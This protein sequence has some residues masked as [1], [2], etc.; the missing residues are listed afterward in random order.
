MEHQT[1][2]PIHP[3]A[4]PVILTT[5]EEHDIWMRAVGRGEVAATTTAGGYAQDRD[6]RDA[7]F[8]ELILREDRIG[9]IDP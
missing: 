4:T 9:G 6:A 2:G 8:S 1:V 3:K 7:I 5:D